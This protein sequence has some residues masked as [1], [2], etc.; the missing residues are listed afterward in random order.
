MGFVFKN[1]RQLWKLI[2]KPTKRKGLDNLK[3][4]R[5]KNKRVE[6]FL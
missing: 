2:T 1:I 6:E 4:I 5:V 3:I